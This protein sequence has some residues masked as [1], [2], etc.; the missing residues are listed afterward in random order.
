MYRMATLPCL[1]AFR[2]FS[3][4]WQCT[5]NGHTNVTDNQMKCQL[6]DIHDKPGHPA[7]PFLKGVE[8]INVF[9]FL[10]YA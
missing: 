5:D 9:K 1:L 7:I 4:I 6:D 2:H 10:S 8:R 3:Y